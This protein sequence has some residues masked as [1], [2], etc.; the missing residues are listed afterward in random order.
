MAIW[1]YEGNSTEGE[2]RQGE[3][4]AE[5]KEEA[6]T[7]LSSI[8][9]KPFQLKKQRNDFEIVIPGITDKVPLKS[10]VVF[11]RQ[12]ATMIDAGLPLIKALDLLGNQEPNPQL[13]KTLLAVK[14]SVEGGSSFSDA[15]ARHPKVFEELYVNLIRAGE[16]GGIIDTIMNRLAE[17]IEKAA[18]TRAKIKGAMKYPVTVLIAALSITAGLLWKVVPTFA[19]T[20]KSMGKSSLP[21]IT[22]MLVA[23]SDNFV[24][25][26]PHMFAALIGTIIGWKLLMKVP[27]MTYY[28]DLALYRSPV[29]G[30]VLRK[31]AVARFTRTLGTLI[32]AGVP[33][34]DAL[35]VVSKTAGN[36]VIE[37]AIEYTRGRIQEGKNV[38]GP[39]METQVFPRMVVQ[40]IAVGE[41]TG[42]MDVM[43]AKIADFYD[44]E[45]DDAVDGMSAV[46]EPLIMVVLGGIIG[47]IMLGMYMPIFTMADH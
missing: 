5:S 39:L 32:S 38:T 1:E 25:Y 26:M 8:G 10:M 47:T 18:A 41:A 28:R 27:N 20:F 19:G 11:T 2:F 42:A 15:L 6:K 30:P 40:M 36:Q 12:M 43:L 13:K 17:Y 14:A 22:E 3:I 4:E 33:I 7:K 29:V 45:V 16:L 35:Q 34:L 46:M 21:A 24:S 23:I 37:R 9:I 31:G 44:D